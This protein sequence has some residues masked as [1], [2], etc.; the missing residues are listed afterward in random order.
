MESYTLSSNLSTAYLVILSSN[1]QCQCHVH[2][3]ALHVV[4]S[5]ENRALESHFLNDSR[6]ERDRYFLSRNICI[7]LN[8]EEPINRCD[9]S[10]P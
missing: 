10:Q 6:Q 5:F 3:G 8:L 9:R 2:A 7:A 4:L 1:K